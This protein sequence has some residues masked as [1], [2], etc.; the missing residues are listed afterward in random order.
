MQKGRFV[1]TIQEVRPQTK[2]TRLKLKKNVDY[3]SKRYVVR[4]IHAP[5]QINR[6]CKRQKTVQKFSK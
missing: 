5:E 1:K 4:K 6:V 3:Y 2:R